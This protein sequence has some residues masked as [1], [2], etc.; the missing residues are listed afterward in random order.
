MTLGRFFKSDLA[1]RESG[2]DTTH[3]FDD[4]ATDFA[5]V[6]LNSLL[7]KYETDFAELIGSQFDGEL[8][9]LATERGEAGFWRRRAA[10]RKRAMMELMWDE[11]RGYFFDY[12]FANRRRSTYVSATG[13]Y[14]LWAKMFDAGDPAER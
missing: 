10:D 14:P 4:R 5:T 13:L 6:D 7:Y 11:Q 8:P 9:G 3:R 12:D 2:H 1:V